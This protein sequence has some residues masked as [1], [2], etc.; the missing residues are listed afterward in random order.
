MNQERFDELLLKHF[1]EIL[2]TELKQK[3][4]LASLSTRQLLTLANAIDDALIPLLVQILKGQSENEDLFHKLMGDH[5]IE[6]KD[7]VDTFF[8]RYM[9]TVM[10]PKDDDFN[11]LLA[12]LPSEYFAD[13]AFLTSREGFFKSQSADHINEFLNEYFEEAPEFNAVEL[14]EAWNWFFKNALDIK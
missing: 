8:E 1:S 5:E 4:D 6:N 12:Y 14:D 2:K 11:P 9:K 10:E 13:I 7:L 3:S